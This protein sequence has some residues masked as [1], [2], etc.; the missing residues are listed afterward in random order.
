MPDGHAPMALRSR[1]P[2]V[3]GFTTWDLPSSRRGMVVALGEAPT[4]VS[5]AHPTAALNGSG[6][7]YYV[8]ATNEDGDGLG[9]DRP[10]A[11]TGA[12]GQ[13]GTTMT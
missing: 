10:D 6:S 9:P 2:S 13:V 12:A 11:W 5:A 3:I 8:L 7:G 1:R 4:Q